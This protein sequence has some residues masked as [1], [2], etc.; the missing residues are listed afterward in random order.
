VSQ[1]SVQSI[2][3]VRD[4]RAALCVFAEAATSAM[5]STSLECQRFSD[6]INHEQVKYWQSE[7][8]RREEQV[9]EA[10]SSL[11]RKRI[12]ATFGD[13]P[14]DSEE[15]ALLKKAIRRLEEAQDKVKKLSKWRQ[16]V[17]RAV[18]EY[19]GQSQQM[20]NFLDG[21]LPKTIALFE[22][23]IDRLE[24]YAGIVRPDAAASSTSPTVSFA[25]PVAAPLT[26]AAETPPAEGP[27]AENNAIPSTDAPPSNQPPAA[28]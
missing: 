8:R 26:P 7:L 9:T 15:Q 24:E 12:A 14:R 25:Q 3:A 21:E 13:P 22:R 5:S 10:K 20:T 11:N 18:T 17:D 23:L 1:A 16:L 6:W 4:F 19:I 28:T 27:P 2:D